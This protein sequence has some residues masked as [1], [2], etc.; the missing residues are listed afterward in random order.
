LFIN[1]LYYAEGVFAAPV[2]WKC[3]CSL[4]FKPSTTKIQN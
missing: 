2:L 3:T 4:Y 1:T